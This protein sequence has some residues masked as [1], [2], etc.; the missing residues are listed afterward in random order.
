[1]YAALLSKK[2]AGGP[3][4]LIARSTLA[5]GTLPDMQTSLVKNGLKWTYHDEDVLA[6]W[7]AEMDFGLAPPISAALHAAV[8]RGQ[9]GYSFPNAI[10]ATAEAAAAFWADQFDWKVDTDRIHAAPDVIEGVSRTIDQLTAPGSPVI[11]PTPA[12]FPFFG[13]VDRTRRVAV[14]VPGLI[15]DEGRY[16]LDIDGIDR[17]F[18]GGAGS[19]VISQPWNPTGTVFTRA[20]I[21][22]LAE[23][24][25][26]HGGRIISDEIHAPLVYEGSEHVVAATVAPDVVATVTSASK[27]FNLPGLKCAQIVLSTDEDEA[28]WEV[29][30]ILELGS[31]GLLG[32][33][34]N[35]AAYRQGLPWL[36]EVMR[37]LD[38]NRLLLGRLLDEQLPDARYRPPDA[39]FLA[40]LDLSA[41]GYEDPAI[42]LLEQGRVAVSSCIPFGEG[43]EGHARLN[44]G[45]SADVLRQIVDRMADCL[46]D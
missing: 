46:V 6:A 33:I 42:H 14:E 40:W 24:V 12:Y 8:D 41:Y 3:V 30:P 36:E 15:D 2:R 11:L 45:T 18:S 5:V 44:F 20:E 37:L 31:I 35:E 23:V 4:S 13:M 39:T 43:V 25:R 19:I 34:A 27:A 16:S 17:A 26:A 22:A 9:T 10:E 32:V 1:M 7:V 21:E 29:D 28:A 38:E